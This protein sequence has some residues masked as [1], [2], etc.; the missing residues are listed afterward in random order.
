[1]KNRTIKIFPSLENLSKY[2][3]EFLKRNINIIL[4]DN[5]FSIALSGGSTPR[6]I[7]SYVAKNYS[8]DINWDRIK[9]FF[10]D[11]RCVPPEDGESNFKMAN[12]NLFKQ[13]KIKSENIFRI[14][15]EDSPA[16]EVLRYS[17]VL[18]NN[19][20][21]KNGIPQFDLIMLGLGEDGHTA[22]IFPNQ[23][24][25]FSSDNLFEKAIHPKSGQT[26]IT[27][28]GSVINSAKLVV[29]VVTGK[30]KSKIVSELLSDKKTK[31]V[32]PASLVNP[33]NGKLVWILDDV[34]A[35][36]LDNKTTKL[37]EQ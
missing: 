13:I 34:A 35:N 6:Q 22:S 18:T 8:N 1:M 10:G 19:V 26:R 29:F 12:D 16:P 28:T 5:Y 4:P 3:A 23:M 31:S 20:S 27:I 14:R 15:G 2:S 33:T 36:L 17:E 25:I 9:I 21:L 30:N 37:S 7:F 32:Y 11:E 24:D